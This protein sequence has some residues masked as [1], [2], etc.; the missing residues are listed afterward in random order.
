MDDLALLLDANTPAQ[1]PILEKTL[2][3][4]PILTGNSSCLLYTSMV[5]EY[6]ASHRISNEGKEK[7]A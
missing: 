4:V 5:S 2:K 7:A 6:Q 1:L 3:L